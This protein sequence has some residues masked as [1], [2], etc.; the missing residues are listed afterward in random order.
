VDLITEQQMTEGERELMNE[1]EE[2][3]E[4]AYVPYSE[5]PVAAAVRTKEGDIFRG[6]NIE[7]ASYGLSICAERTAIFKAI[8]AGCRHLTDI[9]IVL[10]SAEGFGSP[11]GACR[12]VMNEFNE[13]M[14]VIMSSADGPIRRTSLEDLLPHSFGAASL[15][16]GDDDDVE[17]TGTA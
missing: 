11:C 13:R 17:S 10:G 12:Q 2:I 3:L 6:C 5:F 14:N 15:S 4:R 9:A 8:T 7:N 1:A 16:S